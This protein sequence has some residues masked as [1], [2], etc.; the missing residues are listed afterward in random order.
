MPVPKSQRSS[1][2]RG[3]HRARRDRRG[4]HVPPATE[5]KSGRAGFRRHS[6]GRAGQHPTD[7]RG[8]GAQHRRQPAWAG[9]HRHGLALSCHRGAGRTGDRKG[10]SRRRDRSAAG[11]RRRHAG[12]ERTLG[13]RLVREPGR[14]RAGRQCGHGR[15]HRL[16]ERRAVGLLQPRLLA[17]RAT[18]SSSPATTA[19]SIPSPSSGSSS[20]TRDRCRSMRWRDRQKARA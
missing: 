7:R 9:Q 12:P 2:S 17:A 5:R 15:T 18:R 14:S 6:A 20:S 16:L 10:G 1:P 19:S 3:P 8:R 4:C 11:R 13:R